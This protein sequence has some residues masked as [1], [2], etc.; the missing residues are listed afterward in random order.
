M[1]SFWHK[2]IRIHYKKSYLKEKVI[3]V[4]EFEFY[5][6]YREWR[7]KMSEDQYLWKKYLIFHWEKRGKEARIRLRYLEQVKALQLPVL[8]YTFAGNNKEAYSCLLLLA[9]GYVLLFFWAW[10]T[11]FAI[12]AARNRNPFFDSVCASF[13]IATTRN[14][15]VTKS[16]W[17][18]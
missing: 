16:T 13:F 9:W 17:Y 12:I 2:I 7:D 14:P 11:I 5:I 4:R 18:A 15:S 3:K 6:W 1:P 10:D 8:S